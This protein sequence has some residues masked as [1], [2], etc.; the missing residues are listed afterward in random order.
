MFVQNKIILI[1]HSST[2]FRDTFKLSVQRAV[3]Q[4]LQVLVAPRPGGQL[5]AAAPAQPRQA[6]GLLPHLRGPQPLVL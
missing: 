3:L 1:P 2:V 4:L 5:E 6:G